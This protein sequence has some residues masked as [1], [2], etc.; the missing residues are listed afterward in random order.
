MPV[1]LYRFFILRALKLLFWHQEGYFTCRNLLHGQ[2]VKPC[3][4]GGC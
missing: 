4:S 1:I 3:T 2:S